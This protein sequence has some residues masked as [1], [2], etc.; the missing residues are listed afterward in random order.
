MNTE[1]VVMAYLT[2]ITMHLVFIVTFIVLAELSRV[3]GDALKKIRLYRLLYLCALFGFVS[4]VLPL[5]DDVYQQISMLLDA[6]ALVFA[7]VTA[8]Y[9][10]HWIPTELR[11]D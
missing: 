1:L 7:I 4:L 11:K 9:Y 3:L 10:W 6:L 8:A 2:H 5:L